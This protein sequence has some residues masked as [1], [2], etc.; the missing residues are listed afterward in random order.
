MGDRTKVKCKDTREKVVKSRKGKNP[1]YISNEAIKQCKGKYLPS[2][3]PH[4]PNHSEVMINSKLGCYTCFPY[5]NSHNSG[6]MHSTE[7]QILFI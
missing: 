7:L 4:L 2:L 5:G 1:K 3:T 6:L